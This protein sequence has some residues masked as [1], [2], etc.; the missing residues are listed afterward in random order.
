MQFSKQSASIM[1]NVN[2]KYK[3][4][5]ATPPDNANK[6]EDFQNLVVQINQPN[7]S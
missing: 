2:M 5:S 3:H 6:L 1:A 7:L 4:S